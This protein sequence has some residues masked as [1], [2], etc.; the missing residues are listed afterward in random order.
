M[1]FSSIVKLGNPISSHVDQFL[2]LPSKHQLFL[3]QS[4]CDFVA[5]EVEYLDHIVEKDGVYVDPTKIEAMKD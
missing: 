2:H 5:S 1:I 4:K 3:K